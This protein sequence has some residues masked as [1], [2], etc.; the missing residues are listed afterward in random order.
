MKLSKYKKPVGLA[1]KS[2]FVVAVWILF[3]E[4][5]VKSAIPG[6][7]FRVFLLRLFGA[8]IGRGVNIKPRVQVKYPWKLSI[9][10]H[11][12]IGENV[13]IDNLAS[14]SIGNEV[15]ISQGVYFCTGSHDWSKESFDLLVRPITISSYSW[16]C[17]RASIG[18]GAMLEEGSVVEFGC[19]FSG[20][21][22]SWHI[23]SVNR[24]VSHI[25][26]KRIT[27]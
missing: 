26:K 1:K 15:C 6:S 3:G 16:I 7:M 4:P 12:W 17:A 27:K 24:K 2:R 11:S 5:L 14:V 8:K 13:W 18:P 25:I 19:A 20:T 23:F 21:L 22:Q 9:G 10:D